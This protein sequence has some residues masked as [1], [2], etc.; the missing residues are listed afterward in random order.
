MEFSARDWGG[1]I[2]LCE[3]RVL[4]GGNGT[5]LQSFELLLEA[6]NAFVLFKQH[7][8]RNTL[9]WNGPHGVEIFRKMNLCRAEKVVKHFL[10]FFPQAA[11]KLRPARQLALDDIG[12]RR[13]GSSHCSVSVVVRKTVVV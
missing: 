2:S 12:E 13:Y 6:R 8:D 11:A 10:V 5:R 4:C 1:R 9:E 3:I 7:G